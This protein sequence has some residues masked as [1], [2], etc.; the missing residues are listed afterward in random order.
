MDFRIASGKK[1]LSKIG[2]KTKVSYD[3]F[4]TE[5]GPKRANQVRGESLLREMTKFL[6]P[7]ANLGDYLKGE[8]QM[9]PARRVEALSEGWPANRSSRSERR[10]VPTTGLE[11]AIFV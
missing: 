5:N 8:W 10:L 6:Q 7:K 9:E 3:C 1:Q 4:F 2:V 11:A